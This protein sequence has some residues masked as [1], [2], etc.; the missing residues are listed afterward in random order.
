[1]KALTPLKKY[2]AKVFL[3]PTLKLFEVAT[4][5]F[6]PFLVRY[7][8]DEGVAKK[9]WGFTWKTS[10]ILF[11]I[12]LLGFGLT[13][14][15]QYLC[16]RVASDYAHDLRREVFHKVSSL[17]DKQLDTFGKEKILTIVNNE[18]YQY[19]LPRW[20]GA[21]DIRAE[22]QM[23][24]WHVLAE[25]AR[26]ANDPTF[27]NGFSYRDGDAWLL[28][29]GYSRK[30]LAVLAQVK[31]SENMSFRSQRERMG[32]AGRLN[33]MPPFA[34]QHTYSLATQYAYATQYTLGEWAFQGQ[35]YYTWARTT[36]MGGKYGTTLKLN[37][38]HIRGVHKT[39]VSANGGGSMPC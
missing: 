30:G 26:K 7:I 34:Q 18:L 4:E 12:A 23:K 10:L 6:S 37:G 27:E 16:S 32:I 22:W 1:M 11:A 24:G 36:R 13:M 15:A 28:S 9:D 21:G 8:I 33:Y 14:I 29:A 25:Y 38:A 39:N 2:R 31:R 35:V 20:V 5:L 3:A 17:S 19:R